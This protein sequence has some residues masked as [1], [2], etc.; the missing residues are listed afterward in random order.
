MT[1]QPVAM[2][3]GNVTIA[4]VALGT[5]AEWPRIKLVVYSDRLDFAGTGVFGT[6]T[7]TQQ[8]ESIKEIYP[9]VVRSVL[10]W[11]PGFYGKHLIRVITKCPNPY[12]GSP[13][14]WFFFR[15]PAPDAV[16][17]IL[18]SAGYPVDREPRIAGLM[19]GEDRRLP[20]NPAG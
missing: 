10:R 20:G 13:S 12:Q 1:E 11:H 2:L 14:Y 16:L 8:R 3:Q 19:S 15:T 5:K 7:V 17:G 4:N 6:K 9:L 18:A